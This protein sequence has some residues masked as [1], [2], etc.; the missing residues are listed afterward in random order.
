[1][2]AHEPVV[3]ASRPTPPDFIKKRPTPEGSQKPR[4]PM[5]APVQEVEITLVHHPAR[6]PWHGQFLPHF[7]AC[8][9][10]KDACPFFPAEYHIANDGPGVT[11]ESLQNDGLV[12]PVYTNVENYSET[13]G[14]SLNGHF[15]V[16][17]PFTKNPPPAP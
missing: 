16:N 10:Q 11:S 13:G 9:K 12:R 1:M 8:I 17:D 15:Y 3:E 6:D 14:A 7:S 5:V 2:K 4:L